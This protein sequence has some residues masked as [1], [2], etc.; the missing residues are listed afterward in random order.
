MVFYYEKVRSGHSKTAFGVLPKTQAIA[1]RA[2]RGA[3][4][5]LDLWSGYGQSELMQREMRICSSS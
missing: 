5:A 1:V 2:R 4:H 3:L